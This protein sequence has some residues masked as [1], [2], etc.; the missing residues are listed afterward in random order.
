VGKSTEARDERK[1]LREERA[2]RKAL[3]TAEARLGGNHAEV[4]QCLTALGE[5]LYDHNRCE[6]AEPLIRRPWR[7]LKLPLALTAKLRKR[8]EALDRRLEEVM[9]EAARY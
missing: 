8:V 9:K 2:L 6:E 1:A 3:A 5:W 4:G 7:T